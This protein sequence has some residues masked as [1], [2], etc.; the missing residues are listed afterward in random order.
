M[1]EFII[2]IQEKENGIVVGKWDY[3]TEAFEKE[4][5]DLIKEKLKEKKIPWYLQMFI[6]TITNY[7]GEAISEGINE[8]IKRISKKPAEEEKKPVK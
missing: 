1:K 4:L 8:M 6:D 3:S 7:A 2:E 5:K